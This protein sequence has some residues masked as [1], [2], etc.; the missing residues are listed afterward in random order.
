MA[1]G[2]RDFG[3]DAGLFANLTRDWIE[4]PRN[5]RKTLLARRLGVCVSGQEEP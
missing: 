3:H 4:Y 1:E 2:L 5:L